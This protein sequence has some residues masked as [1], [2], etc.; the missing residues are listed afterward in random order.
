MFYLDFL[1]LNPLVRFFLNFKSLGIFFLGLLSI[2]KFCF[3]L[4]MTKPPLNPAYKNMEV[5]WTVYKEV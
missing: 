1:C 5:K 4:T 3:K 2:Y